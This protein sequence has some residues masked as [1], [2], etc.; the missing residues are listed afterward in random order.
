MVS[1]RVLFMS[2]ATFLSSQPAC[3][4]DCPDTAI[5]AQP[6]AP[7]PCEAGLI[8]YRLPS[9]EYK[10]TASAAVQDQCGSGITAS[11]LASAQAS[12]NNRF[13]DGVISI[14]GKWDSD[15]DLFHGSVRCNQGT[16][17]PLRVPSKASMCEHEL[18]RM[19][20]LELVADS[21][22][23]LRVTDTW[24]HP[25]GPGCLAADGCIVTYQ[26]TLER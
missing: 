18:E 20:Q 22:L 4:D 7:G 14:H 11:S 23:V 12:V 5:C 15:E 6:G 2:V 17:V 1:K 9:S 10:V 16:S 3:H 25:T 21:T 8:L 24:H 26:V 13:T 19:S